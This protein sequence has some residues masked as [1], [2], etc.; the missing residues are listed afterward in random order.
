MHETHTY[1]HIIHISTHT[2]TR[3]LPYQ[4]QLVQVQ[5][6]PLQVQVQPVLAVLVLVLEAVCVMVSCQQGTSRHSQSGIFL[7]SLDMTCWC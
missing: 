2:D 7:Q 3:D 4:P 6:T 5:D 1:T